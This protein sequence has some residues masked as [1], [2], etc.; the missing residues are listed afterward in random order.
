MK[1]EDN[2]RMMFYTSSP[3]QDEFVAIQFQNGRPRWMFDTQSEHSK[4]SC[5]NM[6]QSYL[7]SAYGFNDLVFL[8]NRL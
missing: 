6:W 3:N 8:K 4:I 5:F 1:K 2:L 7:C